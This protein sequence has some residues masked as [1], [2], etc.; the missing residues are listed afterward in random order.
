[1]S[2]TCRTCGSDFDSVGI[3]QATITHPRRLCPECVN[4]EGVGAMTVKSSPARVISTIAIQI[5]TDEGARTI[6]TTASDEIAKL[7]RD[8][9]TTVGAFLRA[10]RDGERVL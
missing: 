4:R 2:A 3:L 5:D 8:E 7:L 6:F 1:M 10:I 9:H